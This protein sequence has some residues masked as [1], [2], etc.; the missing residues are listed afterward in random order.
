MKRWHDGVADILP[1]AG[2]FDNAS[3]AKDAKVLGG[4]VLSNAEVGGQLVNGR[5][6]VHQFLDKIPPGIIGQRLEQFNAR[7]RL[8]LWLLARFQRHDSKFS[9]RTIGGKCVHLEQGLV[10]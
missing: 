4:I 7:D 8:L 9:A 2:G 6:F 1:F 3:F 10:R 5:G